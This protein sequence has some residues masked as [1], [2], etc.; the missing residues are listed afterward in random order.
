MHRYWQCAGV[1]REASFGD[2]KR[3][4]ARNR[5]APAKRPA[6]P[7]RPV[8]GTLSQNGYGTCHP[9]PCDCILLES[10]NKF[11][12]V[13]F[14]QHFS[15]DNGTWQSWL[16]CKTGQAHISESAK[17]WK[18]SSQHH[19]QAKQKMCWV[20]TMQQEKPGEKISLSGD[21]SG[22]CSDV[23]STHGAW[24]HAGVRF[25]LRRDFALNN[26]VW[27]RKY[28]AEWRSG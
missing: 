20:R 2:G 6:W 19:G 17:P 28:W 12:H 8:C 18:I 25:L 5:T 7:H 15:S 24:R 9:H 11:I 27:H 22:W 1:F 23:A 16:A 10:G 21:E 3:P 13:R 4:L 14:C 26:I